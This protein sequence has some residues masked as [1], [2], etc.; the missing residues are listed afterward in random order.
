MSLS[1]DEFRDGLRMRYGIGLEDLPQKCDG[2][3]GEFTVLYALQYKKGGV[4][5]MKYNELKN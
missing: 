4:V 2:S 3:G 5:V 1:K